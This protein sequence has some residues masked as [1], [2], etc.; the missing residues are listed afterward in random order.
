MSKVLS[1]TV[2]YDSMDIIENAKL[3]CPVCEHVNKK[4]NGS[5]SCRT[6]CSSPVIHVTTHGCVCT[7]CASRWEVVTDEG[8]E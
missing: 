8:D 6:A 5:S 1:V 3:T 2:T 7:M 4:F